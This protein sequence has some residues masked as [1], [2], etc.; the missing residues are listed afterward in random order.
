MCGK[1][2]QRNEWRELVRL[3][4]IARANVSPAGIETITPIRTAQV[5]ALDGNGARKA[6]PM[7]WGLIPPHAG[8]ARD[9]K[10]HIHARAETI[11]TKPTFRES[12]LQRRGLI[13]VSTFNEGEEVG[14]KTVQYV[15]TPKDGRHIAIAVIWDRWRDG[16]PSLL[17]F[18]MVTTPPCEI[19]GTI[20]DRMPALLED[21]DWPKWLGEEPASVEELKAMLHVSPR[22]LD[23]ERT[24]K[25]PPPPKP[26]RNAGQAELF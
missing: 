19:I 24:S 9:A 7:R 17:T 10:P 8:N 25:P 14:S 13:V 22:D 5:I 26:A 11:D 18:A 15:C 20:T 4:E 2:T 16:G 21:S 3:D 23:M 1:F 12:F 6:V